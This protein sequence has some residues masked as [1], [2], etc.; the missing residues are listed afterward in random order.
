MCMASAER[1]NGGIECSRVTHSGVFVSGGECAW[2][3]AERAAVRGGRAREYVCFP[4]FFGPHFAGDVHLWAGDV[5]V[6]V[7]SAGHD[8]EAVRIDFARGTN[9]GIEWR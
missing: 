4:F 8:N 7:D 5:A 9:S 2:H 1:R 6:H 3:A